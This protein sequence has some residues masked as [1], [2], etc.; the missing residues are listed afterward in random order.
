MNIKR[1][2]MGHPLGH[3]PPNVYS[4][5]DWIRRHEKELLEQ[6]GECSIIVYKEQVLGIGP[7][8]QAALD[9]AER[10]LLPDAGEVTPVHERLHDRRKFFSGYFRVRPTGSHFS[11]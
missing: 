3:T 2:R 8:Y 1:I 5:F 6:Y 10:N 9:D 7:T 4:D 11:D